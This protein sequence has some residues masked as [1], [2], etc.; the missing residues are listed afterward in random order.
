MIV[1]SVFT[2]CKLCILGTRTELFLNLTTR[3]AD[4][5]CGAGLSDA[6]RAWQSW[7]SSRGCRP[8]TSQARLKCVTCLET[9]TESDGVFEL[10]HA[11]TPSLSRPW[12]CASG[13]LA[14]RWDSEPEAGPELPKSRSCI[15]N[16]FGDS[17]AG[18]P[19]AVPSRG[20]A[21]PAAVVGPP[22][23]AMAV[24]VTHWDRIRT[25][26][27]Q[28]EL[29]QLDSETVEVADFEVADGICG[30]NR[31]GLLRQYKL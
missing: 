20:P 10:G 21:G 9:R 2:V 30:L 6:A 28:A 8:V 13:S 23:S 5:L 14:P 25:F 3:D 24:T 19:P 26:K 1:P 17:A 31:E 22:G 12:H 18:P 29:L 4:T 15:S 7:H 16:V 27:P 11:D